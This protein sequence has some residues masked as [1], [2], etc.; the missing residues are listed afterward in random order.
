MPLI[1]IDDLSDPRLVDYAHLTDVALKKAR[2]T[3]HGLYIAESALVLERALRAG[4]IPR[5]VLALGNTADE[6]LAVLGA[7]AAEV[8]V[9]VGPSALL[10]DL[11]GYILH[12]GLIAAMHRPELPSADSLLADARRIVILENVADPTNVGAIFRSA[13]AIGADAILVTPRCSDPFYRRA[14]RVSMGTVL[15]V[16]WTRA[17]DWTETR[18][19]LTR[20]GFHV[21]ALALT[22]DAVSLRDFDGTAHERLALLLGAEGEGLTPEALAASDT[23][24]QI[25]MKHGID[26]LNVAAASAVAMW[27]LSG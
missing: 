27:A 19:L 1:A 23:V 8:P 11:T 24:V 5:S 12:R 20:H 14:I 22:P 26:S 13:G 16:P 18:A 3:E 15:Q 6:A 10:A 2:G 7:Y 21:A 17:G 9:F 4:H 25:P